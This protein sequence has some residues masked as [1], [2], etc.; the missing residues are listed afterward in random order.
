[1][2]TTRASFSDKGSDWGYP[3]TPRET[4]AE[5][6]KEGWGFGTGTAVLATLAAVGLTV[7]VAG[8]IQKGRSELQAQAANTIEGYVGRSQPNKGTVTIPPGLTAWDSPEAE[9]R[10]KGLV[11]VRG[12]LRDPLVLV[13][14]PGTQAPAAQAKNTGSYPAKQ[15]WLA[16]FFDPAEP[17]RL[18]WLPLGAELA[19]AQPQGQRLQ[20]VRTEMT[21]HFKAGDGQDA[22]HV[23]AEAIWAGKSD[24]FPWGGFQA[25]GGDNGART[26]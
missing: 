24:G 14:R 11:T 9:V 3:V 4:P 10:D 19:A 26:E 17:T 12:V 6:N 22:N 2:I 13:V 7:G 8:G 23:T 20:P 1:M 21:A 16:G 18:M 15:T 25:A 5:T